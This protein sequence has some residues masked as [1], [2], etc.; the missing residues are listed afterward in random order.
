MGVILVGGL[1]LRAMLLSVD[2]FL[3]PDS[4]RYLWDA[5]IT[6]HGYS[7]YVYAPLNALL[8]PLRDVAYSKMAFHQVPS[9][10]PPG[11]QAIYLISYLIAPGNLVM[12]KSIFL[13]FDM[14]TCIVLTYVLKRKGLDPARVI[15]YAW[16][17][18]PIVDF[19]IQGHLDVLAIC[20]SVL[21]VASDLN[22]HNKGSRVLTGF[23][24]GLATLAKIYPILLLVVVLRRRDWMLLLSC[25]AT[26][27]LGYL[28]YIILGHGQVFGFFATYAD[29]HSP[30]SGLVPQIMAWISAVSGFNNVSVEHIIEAA[31]LGGAALS[32]LWLRRRGR[33]GVEAGILVLMGMIFVVSSHVFPWYTTALLPWVAILLQPIWTR[34][35]GLNAGGLAVAMAWYFS[36]ATVLHYLFDRQLDW[37]V[38][39]I[40]VY[41]VVILGVG[42]AIYAGVK[43]NVITVS[44]ITVSSK[45]IERA[46]G[47]PHMDG[48][49]LAEHPESV[50][51]F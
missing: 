36:C 35:N 16:C 48:K 19:A 23:L 34:R 33:I 3:S 50:N 5:H 12:L 41:D 22:D 15:I 25:S 42:I 30:N 13:L 46:S 28:P 27:L 2:P 39:Y 18:L 51:R 1:A 20:F 31:L 4:W 45:R 38:Y 6:L 29:E 14:V 37:T 21:A 47:P 26:I 9:I 24:I 49:S 44:S 11:A 7:P 8:T 17:P 32:V 40:V 43:R 10:Y